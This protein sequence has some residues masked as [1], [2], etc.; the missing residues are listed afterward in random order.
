MARIWRWFIPGLNLKRWLLLFAA[1][2]FLMGWGLSVLLQGGELYTRLE[3]LLRQATFEGAL[4]GLRIPPWL[5]GVA[6]GALGALL[7][8]LAMYRLVRSIIETLNPGK[9]GMAE[10]FYQRRQLFRGP[11]LVAIGG[12]TGLPAVLR[13]MK[14]FTVNITAVVTVADDGGS[15]GKLRSQFGILPPGDIRNC[16]VALSDSE[17]LLEKLFQYRFEHG[18]GLSGHNFG[19]LFIL[20]LTETTGDFYQAV[21]ESSQVLAVRG[22]VIPSSLDHVRLKAELADGTMVVGE[23]AI[24]RAVSPIRRVFLDPPAAHPVEDALQAVADADV[25]V[26]GPGSLYTS[27]IPNL[28]VPGMA[29]ALRRSPAI[30]VYVCNIMTQP[31]ETDGYTA[32]AHVRALIEHV[33]YGCIDHVVVNTGAVPP[34]TVERYRQGKAQPVAADEAELRR[35]GLDVVRADLVELL[36]GPQQPDRPEAVVELVRHH[37]DKLARTI[38]RLALNRPLRPDR[39]PWEFLWLRQRLA[40]LVRA[41]RLQ[42]AGAR[43]VSPPAP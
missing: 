14:D 25:I 15:S 21:R 24:G 40:E 22:R 8:F 34:A 36:P 26:L 39:P 30:K 37:P 20:A 11:K 10:K 27:I 1:G 33:G 18:E 4:A 2:V 13:G 23:S 9:T 7:S 19:N 17:P 42:A 31:G 16:L 5:V 43:K 32:S 6:A 12:G 28:L 35:L 38:S 41:D 3:R 29:D